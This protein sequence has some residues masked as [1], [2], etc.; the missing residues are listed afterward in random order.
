MVKIYFS[1]EEKY[2]LLISLFLF[3]MII[4]G[5]LNEIV[6]DKNSNRMP[7]LADYS[8]KDEEYFSFNLNTNEIPKLWILSDIIPFKNYLLSVGDVLLF[9]SG[10]CFSIISWVY[11]SFKYKNAIDYER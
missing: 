8:Y 5:C 2:L 10:F 4:G 9:F 3:L 6:M 11:T 1:K 7:F